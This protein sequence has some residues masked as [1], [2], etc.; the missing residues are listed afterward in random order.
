MKKILLATSIA[1]TATLAHS[2]LGPIPIYLNTEYRTDSPVIGSIASTLSFN[3]ADIKASG[4]STFLDFLETVPSV[5]LVNAYGNVPAIYIRGGK[6]DHTLILVDGVSVIGADSLNGEIGHGLRAIALG[7]IEKIDIIKGAG[8]VL[9]GSSAIAGIIAITT[10]KGANGEQAAIS[11]KFGTHNA[12]TYALSASNGDDKGG[13]VRFTH[14]QYTTDGINART[15]DLTREKDGIGNH[16]TQ[17]KFGNPQFNAS[18]VENHNKTEYDQCWVGFVAINDC[19]GDRKSKK[20]AINANQQMNAVWKVKLS[21][22]QNKSNSITKASNT[23]TLSGNFKST[24]IRILNDIKIDNALLNVGLLQSN[25]ENTTK[26]KKMSSKDVFVNWQKNI[27]SIDINTGARY[28]KHSKFGGESIYNLGV[29]KYFNNG[30]KLT[31]SYATAFQAPTLKNLFGYNFNGASAGGNLELKPETSKN[32]ELGLEKQ[33][34]WGLSSIRIYQN[35]V[36]NA[37]NWSS[38]FKN[39]DEIKSKGV[40]FSVDANVANYDISFSHNYNKSR[41]NDGNTQNLRRPKNI[42]NLTLSKIIGKFHSRVQIINKS[43]SLDVGNVRL[44]GYTLLNLS[45]NYAINDN[46]KVVFNIK[47]ATDKDY[48]VANGFK[49]FGRTIEA[50]LDYKF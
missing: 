24:N 7:D 25:D 29:A 49:Q 31:S 18:Y 4:A 40:E 41:T 20:I 34:S 14:N 16:T 12:K 6:A 46:A 9:Y 2:A 36:K 3:Q 28:I 33:H 45:T 19:L 30:I 11:T 5:G 15:Q 43:S 27:N 48:I 44:E 47:N 23:S 38:G 1:L 35:K 13:F 26:N 22:A 39:I 37:I 32:I 42:T 8:S 21:L 17:I 50:G 10:K